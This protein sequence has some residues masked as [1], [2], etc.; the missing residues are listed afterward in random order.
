MVWHEFLM[1]RRGPKPVN[2]NLLSGWE[3][4]YYKAFHLLRDGYA[5]PARQRP[6]V[7]SL[8]RL[9]ASQ[10]LSILK[11]LN[12]DDYYLAARKLAVECGERLNLERPAMLVDVEWAESQRSEE[13]VWLER[14]LKPNRPIPAIT[15]KKIWNDLLRARTYADVRKACRRWCRL[16]TVRRAGLTPFPDHIKTNA[17][18]FLAVKGD[19]RFPKS[20]YSDDSRIQF[21]ARGMAGIMA[22]VSPLTGVERLRNMKHTEGGPFWVEREGD[23]PLSRDRQYCGC[24]RCGLDRGNRFAKSVQTPYDNG[25]RAFMEIAAETKAPKEWTTWGLRRNWKKP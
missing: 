9:E 8:S 4:E 3:F 19:K 7:S 22:S 1:G 16:P 20:N 2:Y 10:Y 5:L 24:W 25:F 18:Q 23:Q 14:L 12:A 17:A 13:I 15:G 11:R 21:L 6:P